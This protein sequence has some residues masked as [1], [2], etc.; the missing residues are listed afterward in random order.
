MERIPHVDVIAVIP[1]E[2]SMQGRAA[3]AGRT[4]KGK[5][6][7]RECFFVY[8]LE[9]ERRTDSEGDTY[10]ATIDQGSRHAGHFLLKDNTGA[11]LVSLS[12]VS[13]DLEED[14]K[15]SRGDR[16]YT[17]WRIDEG[18]N[19]FA[20]AMA[21][22]IP[23]ERQKNSSAS[24]S[25]LAAG[26]EGMMLTF[27]N[28]GSYVPILSEYTALQARKA[29]GTN[30]ILMTLGSALCFIFGILCI[31]FLM[32]VHRVLIFLSIVSTLNLLVLFFMGLN[33]M[34]SDLKDGYERLDRHEKSARET[35][36]SLLKSKFEWASLPQRVVGLPSAK[37]A[38]VLGIRNDL[39]A[40]IERSNAIRERFPE[41][42]LA[43]M[44]DIDPKPSIL[45]SGERRSAEADRPKR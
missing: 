20:F 32:K 27:T 18:Q 28:S 39:S 14:Y 40:S 42:W 33:M 7:G 6:S 44:W 38:R 19:V 10:W 23:A 5:Y 17:E 21:Q 22:K 43:P 4:I 1:G 35:V 9:E 15:N 30:G 29:Q 26:S 34:N 3:S 41:S 12:D 45:A 16:R 8:W 36:Q 31:C 25:K 37:T 2:V 13:P 11:I 24:G